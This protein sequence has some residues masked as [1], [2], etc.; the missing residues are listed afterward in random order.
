MIDDESRVV[1]ALAR[2]LGS[3]HQVTCAH[4]AQEALTQ[5]RS[6]AAWDV[7]LC[8]V[9]M[10]HMTGLELHGQLSAERPD[11]AERFI[12]MTGGGFSPRVQ[13]ALDSTGRALLD[14]PLDQSRLFSLLHAHAPS[15]VKDETLRFALAS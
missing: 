10:P 14:K 3:D 9:M 2:M 6:G 5:M 11:L 1:K 7:V 12:F 4:G 15:R 8:D 13:Q